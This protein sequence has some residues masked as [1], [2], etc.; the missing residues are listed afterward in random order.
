MKNFIL[1]SRDVPHQ[2]YNYIKGLTGDNLIVS[3]DD[4]GNN[5]FSLGCSNMYLAGGLFR[6]FFYGEKAS[7]IDIFFRNEE[8]LD[9]FKR[10]V[11]RNSFDRNDHRDYDNEYEVVFETDRAISIQNPR[12]K[13]QIQLIKA[14]F[15]PTILDLLRNFDFTIAMA[16]IDTSMPDSIYHVK[17]YFYDLTVKRLIYTG[18]EYPLASLKRVTKFIRRGFSICD[19]N[20]IRIAEDISD[21][22]IIYDVDKDVDDNLDIQGMDPDGARSIYPFD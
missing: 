5:H 3:M 15:P 12:T 22:G 20:L 10:Y 1:E 11:C 17:D 7:D 6:S 13:F 19:E 2:F 8:D 21:K 14:V 18:S 9:E 16:G 4:D